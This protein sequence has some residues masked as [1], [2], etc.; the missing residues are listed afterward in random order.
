MERSAL[1]GCQ[2]S[3][4]LLGLKLGPFHSFPE[5]YEY[6]WAAIGS[7]ALHRQGGGN[8]CWDS[9]VLENCL[10]RIFNPT[11][12]NLKKISFIT[13]FSQLPL[14]PE[15]Q[16]V[17]LQSIFSHRLTMGNF[18]NSYL[19]LPWGDF[20]QNFMGDPFGQSALCVQTGSWSVPKQKFGK[21][22]KLPKW[23]CTAVHGWIGF[24]H[25]VNFLGV[26]GIFPWWNFQIWNSPNNIKIFWVWRQSSAILEC[27]NLARVPQFSSG[28]DLSHLQMP[29]LS[30]GKVRIV[31]GPKIVTFP[32]FLRNPCSANDELKLR[33]YF[34]FCW[35]Q[36]L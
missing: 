3:T 6:S 23:P 17:C 33:A 10:K 9:Q 34:R 22:P 30:Y 7:Y 20:P 21:G 31:G 4:D 15:S 11:S 19:M 35:Y 16:H 36:I 18:G 25:C 24:L 5:G 2:M 1:F 29:Y 27:Q 12:K 8:H 14:T 28:F 13:K 32:N 26:R